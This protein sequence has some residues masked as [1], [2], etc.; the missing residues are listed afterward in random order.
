MMRALL[1]SIWM[2]KTS[3]VEGWA[4]RAAVRPP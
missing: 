4:F 3:S 1:G 2:R